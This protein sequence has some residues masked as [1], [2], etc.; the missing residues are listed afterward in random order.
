MSIIGLHFSRRRGDPSFSDGSRSPDD[1]LYTARW[2][3]K[4]TVRTALC[5]ACGKH[6]ITNLQ[7]D[8]DAVEFVKSLT[9]DGMSMSIGFSEFMS[10]MAYPWASG[11]MVSAEEDHERIVAS[12]DQAMLERFEQEMRQWDATRT[13][14]ESAS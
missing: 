8:P 6:F 12:L 7:L 13:T 4:I 9:V 11:S 14:S 10:C 3:G 1:V 2:D 5:K